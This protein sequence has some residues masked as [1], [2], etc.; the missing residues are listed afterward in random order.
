VPYRAAAVML[1]GGEGSTQL[2]RPLSQG[3][4]FG[5]SWELADDQLI[6]DLFRRW[7]Y[8]ESRKPGDSAIAIAALVG[9]HV[10]QA[11]QGR[12]DPFRRRFSEGGRVEVVFEVFPGLEQQTIDYAAHVIVIAEMVQGAIDAFG[13][14][15]AGR[16][17]P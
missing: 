8:H 16:N 13:C 6:T 12:E 17:T 5:R 7:E 2:V 3:G 14:R 9:G 1:R 4:G 10:V 11:V 15:G